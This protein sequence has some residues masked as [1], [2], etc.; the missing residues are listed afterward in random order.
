MNIGLTYTGSEQKH[1]NYIRWL[2]H[3]GNVNV[4]TLSAE[5][6]ENKGSIEDCD[7]LVLSGGID[8]HPGYYNSDNIVYP[9]KPQQFYEKRDAFEKNLFSFYI[10]LN[11]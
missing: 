11:S 10:T 1:D 7:A 8:I 5:T 3:D 4:I 6:K 9:N 2:K